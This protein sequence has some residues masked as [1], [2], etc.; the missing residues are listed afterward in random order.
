MSKAK[1]Y[2]LAILALCP[3]L[4]ITPS[5]AENV[6]KWVDKNGVTHY[7]DEER[8]ARKNNAQSI[9]V[10]G[11]GSLNGSGPKPTSTRYDSNYTPNPHT[12][13]N[14]S[15][16]A[17]SNHSINIVSPSQGEEIR[18]N[19]GVVM[20]STNIIPR[21]RGDY[22]LKVYVDGS[23]YA[24]ANNSTKVELTA[25]SRG[26]HDVLVKLVLKNGKIIASQPVH[27]TVLRASIGRK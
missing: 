16:V 22:S 27:F 9:N 18:A 2:F 7:G 10:N 14:G 13:N 19:N 26:E 20:L 3:L 1:S 21:P 23:L 8:M 24:S 6:Y 25:M 12:I 11:T 5:H 17:N 15:Y 4:F